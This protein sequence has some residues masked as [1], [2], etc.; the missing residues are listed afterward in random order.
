VKTLPEIKI[1]T[2]HESSRRQFIQGRSFLGKIREIAGAAVDVAN[3]NDDLPLID[4]TE[5]SPTGWPLL[6]FVRSAM[7][8]DFEISFNRGQYPQAAEAAIAALDEVERLESV[9]SSFRSES[10]I[11]R[12]NRD[13]PQN[14]V[15]VSPEVWNLLVQCQQLARESD[16]AIDLTASRLWR[17]WGFAKREGKIPPQDEITDA[18]QN[19]GTSLVQLDADSQSV[20]FAKPGIEISLGCIGKGAALD[21]ALCKLRELDIEHALL[22]GGR[23]SIMAV[24]GRMRETWPHAVQ[25][26][27]PANIS[28]TLLEPT[29]DCSDGWTIGISHPIRQGRRLAEVRL[30][31]EALGTSGS[32]HQFFI[33]QGRRYSHIID[34]RSGWPAEGVLMATVIAPTAAL[35]DALST[36]FFVLR[37]EQTAGYCQQHPG[38]ATLLVLPGD[39]EASE[40]SNCRILHFGFEQNQIRF[41]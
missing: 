11:S 3:Q 12:I 41:F 13:A 21:S 35:A 40:A 7:A 31:N 14:A 39:S 29:R 33:H 28:G 9:L 37:P 30:T 19:V 4:G 25:K 15:A 24:G 36:A 27:F 10:E 23:S 26:D 17:L 22:H 18:L 8:S 2:N 38:V 16:G 1:M 32:Q 6:R 5:T 20:R 34:P